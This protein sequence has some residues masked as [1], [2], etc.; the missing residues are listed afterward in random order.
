M[1]ELARWA[2]MHTFM[3]ED[4]IQYSPPHGPPSTAS[5]DSQATDKKQLLSTVG[6]DTA[7]PPPHTQM[8][9]D[10]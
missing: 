9:V 3:Q 4:Q 6:D 5:H 7:T 10:L 1:E 2:E 8:L